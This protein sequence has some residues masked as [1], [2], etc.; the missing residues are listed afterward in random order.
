M[1]TDEGIHL[2]TN[3][4]G[5]GWA[6]VASGVVLTRHKTK[7]AAEAKGRR[8]ARRHGE[9]YTIHRQDGSIIETKSYAVVPLAA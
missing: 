5:T 4:N 3:P 9:R 1:N 8:L 7:D 2:T 6:N